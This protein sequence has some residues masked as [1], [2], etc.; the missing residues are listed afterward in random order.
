M[1]ILEE[2]DDL[3]KIFDITK[4]EESEIFSNI[5]G[6]ATVC[7]FPESMYKTDEVNINNVINDIKFPA[8]FIGT[9]KI[10]GSNINIWY[11]KGKFGICSRNQGRPLTYRKVVGRRLRWWEHIL[12]LFGVK[13]KGELIYETANSEDAFVKHGKPYLDDLISF[14]KSNNINLAIRGEFCGK[15]M[16][17]SGNTNNPHCKDEVHVEFFGVDNYDMISSR[18]VKYSWNT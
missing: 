17:G 2:D 5:V 13:V 9:E 6:K 16:R 18:R 10:D 14:C 1:M 4:Y 7:T 11:K 12:K 15:G 3:A 8:A